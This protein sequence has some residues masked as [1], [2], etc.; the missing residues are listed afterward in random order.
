MPLKIE[1]MINL[2]NAQIESLSLHRVG[3]KSRNENLFIS[4]QPFQLSDELSPLIKEYFLKSFREKE[5]NYYQFIH[6]DGLDFN[7]LY[8]LIAEAFDNPSQLHDF[9]KK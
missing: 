6:E 1:A 9:S 2:F 8:Q 7:P 5:E 3:N 4:Q